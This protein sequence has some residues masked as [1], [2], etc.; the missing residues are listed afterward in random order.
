VSF[1]LDLGGGGRAARM[2]ITPKAG[3]ES[4]G[5]RQL[6]TRLE[7]IT[8][9]LNG[10][11]ITA[12]LGGEAAQVID[13]E[14]STLS[15]LAMLVVL[16]AALNFVLLVIVLRSLLVPLATVALNLVTVGATFGAL[17]LLFEGHAPLG[18]PGYLNT[19]ALTGTFTVIFTLSLDYQVFLLARV[20][21]GYAASGSNRAAIDY[22]LRRTSAVILGAAFAMV[23]VFAA[24]GASDFSVIRQLGVGLTIAILLD[25]TVVRLVLL[26]AL[27][28]LCGERSWRLPPRLER[29]IPAAPIVA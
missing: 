18:G 24:F 19:L 27:I 9:T 8:R 14:H 15:R 20:R 2:L 1:V 16:L 11:G 21:E 29:L 3:L 17:R 12:R 26:P 7:R 25:A 23:A 13:Y 28:R 10:G 6:R 5:S 4:A 22:G